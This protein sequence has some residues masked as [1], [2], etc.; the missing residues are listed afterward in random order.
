MFP[1]RRSTL[2][3]LNLIMA[4]NRASVRLKSD[5]SMEVIRCRVSTEHSTARANS[6]A[7]ANSRTKICALSPPTR[8]ALG[9]KRGQ[10]ELVP[11]LLPDRCSAKD[12][13]EAEEKSS[14][15]I[16]SGPPQRPAPRKG[17]GLVR[18]SGKPESGLR[19]LR[20]SRGPS[21]ASRRRGGG[22]HALP[23][24]VEEEEASKGIKMAGGPSEVSAFIRRESHIPGTSSTSTTGRTVEVAVEASLIA[25]VSMTV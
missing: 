3:N 24:A 12:H 14:T 6:I 11:H 20:V 23:G 25:L 8:T 16:Q 10:D 15:P 18:K 22:P 9:K 13:E 4:R 1:V 21:R 2:L 19:V 17:L 5:L 7:G